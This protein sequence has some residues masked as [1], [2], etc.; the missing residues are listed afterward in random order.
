MTN[1]HL[2]FGI[3]VVEVKPELEVAAEVT[4]MLLTS[5]ALSM[6]HAALEVAIQGDFLAVVQALVL[7]LVAF[8]LVCCANV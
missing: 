2:L 7:V 5:V 6:A 8:D 4:S 1:Q 3:V